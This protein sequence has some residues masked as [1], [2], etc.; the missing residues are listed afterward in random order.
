M[1]NPKGK[2]QGQSQSHDALKRYPDTKCS[3]STNTG[4]IPGGYTVDAYEGTKFSTI[5]HTKFS[6]L[7]KYPD[8]VLLSRTKLCF[9]GFD[10][11]TLLE[12]RD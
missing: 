3:R 5:V 11:S 12:V 4:V 9:S 7:K 10:L 6:A 1:W 8:T 2:D